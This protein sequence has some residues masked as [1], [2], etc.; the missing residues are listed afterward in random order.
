MNHY[1]EYIYERDVRITKT[2]AMAMFYLKD[3]DLLSLGCITKRNPHYRNAP[4]MKL[5]LEQDVQERSLEVHGG[6]IGIQAVSREVAK[7]R[8]VVAKERAQGLQMHVVQNTGKKK[9]EKNKDT[10]SI[11]GKMP[12]TQAAALATYD[13]NIRTWVKI[14]E[15]PQRKALVVEAIA[16]AERRIAAGEPPLEINFKSMTPDRKWID[17]LR[18]A[19]NANASTREEIKK[20]VQD[21]EAGVYDALQV[22]WALSIEPAAGVVAGAMG[23]TGAGSSSSMAALPPT[24]DTT[25]TAA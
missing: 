5:Y 8:R 4:P 25:F 21:F 9:T 1:G 19:L 13:E 10:S 16:E 15:K 11:K 14:L 17:T 2:D 3:D 6:W 22:S 12:M 20:I 7:T 18:F 23:L 24:M